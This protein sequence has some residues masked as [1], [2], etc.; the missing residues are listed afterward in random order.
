MC[1]FVCVCAFE[2]QFLSQ[3]KPNQ[4]LIKLI[5]NSVGVLKQNIYLYKIYIHFQ[6]SVLDINHSL[7]LPIREGSSI[8]ER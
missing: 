2:N 4:L 6:H 1:V 7:I 3:P 5:S 8:E